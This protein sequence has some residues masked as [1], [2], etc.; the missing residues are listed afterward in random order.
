[1]LL[2]RASP[3]ASR[4]P[5]TCCTTDAGQ[6]ILDALR[7]AREPRGSAVLPRPDGA[8]RGRAASTARSRSTSRDG[9]A[10]RTLARP[11][12][13][14]HQLPRRHV[15][16]PASTGQH[17]ARAR[18]GAGRAASGRPRF[19]AATRPTR[20]RSPAGGRCSSSSRRAPTTSQRALER[21][22]GDGAAISSRRTGRRTCRDR[23]HPC[24]PVSRQRVLPRR[25][26]VGPDRLLLRLQRLRSPTTSPICLNAWCFESDSSF[27]VTKGAA[28]LRAPTTRCASSPTAERRGAAD[29]GARR[30]AALPAD[31]ALRLAQHAD[32]TR[33]CSRK[34][35]IEYLP[36]AALPPRRASRLADYGLMSEPAMT[37]RVELS[38]PTAP[39][40]AIPDRAAGRAILRVRRAVETRAVAAASRATTN[41]RME[42]M[43]R[44][45]RR[46]EALKR[47]CRVRLAHR[48]RL[49]CATAS[50]RWIH[51]WKANGWRTADMRAAVKNVELRNASSAAR[52]GH[53]VRSGS[54]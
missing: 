12:G 19:R 30:G 7:E 40:A 34:D 24:R 38:S 28:L 45:R 5:T 54:G 3:K 10:L 47:P 49:S 43:A 46:C 8:P 9:N 35:P 11:A 52:D 15:A 23:R 25:R 4:T 22:L 53:Q 6:Y 2:Q 29:A 33:W 14:D 13:R 16:A 21:E 39:A 1:M 48:Q 27:N 50:P 26:A 42:L 20:C 37:S 18:R 32:R 31:A 44:D 17:C 41:N 51:G 36:Q